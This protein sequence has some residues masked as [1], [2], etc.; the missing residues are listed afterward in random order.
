MSTLHL[1]QLAPRDD[2]RATV[3][4]DWC[5]DDGRTRS[6]EAVCVTGLDETTRKE[7]RWYFEDYLDQL[8]DPPVRLRAARIEERMAV[9][10]EALFRDLFEASPEA[11]EIWRSISE[12]IA[13][14][15]MEITSSV[16]SATAIPWELVQD[17]RAGKPLALIARSFVRIPSQPT[18]TPRRIDLREGETLRILLVICRPDALSDVPFRSVASRLVKELTGE[19]SKRV[20]LTALR[21]PTYEQF[22]TVL[23]TA[24]RLGRPFHL[25]H[26][27]GH[28]FFGD[29]GEGA[30]T[31]GGYL[32]FEDTTRVGRR[33]YVDGQELGAL[34]RE[35][36][37]AGLVLNA[38]QSADDADSPADADQVRAQGSVA[39]E[40]VDA[41][42]GAVLAMRY[43]VYVETATHYVERFY[44][45]L[46]AG[47][48]FGVAATAARAAL[49]A[50]PERQIGGDSAPFRD[51]LVPVV[52]EASPLSVLSTRDAA[53]IF[54]PAGS[55]ARTDDGLPHPPEI[56][57]I[58]GDATLLELDRA[59]DVHKTILLHAYAGSGKSTTAVEFARWY[60]DTRGL[61]GP[62]WLESFETYRPLAR[63]LDRIEETFGDELETKNVNWSARTVGAP[64][65]IALEILA[66]TPVFWIWDNVEE[67]AGFPAGAP[68]LWSV[69]EQTALR[70]FLVRLESTQARVLL[71]SRRDER[72]WLG[73][74]PMR[75]MPGPMPMR[76]RL[77]MAGALA[78]RHGRDPDAIKA[79]RP[80]L[81]WTQGNPM[82]LT[83]VVGQALRDSIETAPL[84]GAFVERL[85][86]GEQAFDDDA[87]QG[88]SRSLG[89][90]L[91][92]GFGA[93]FTANEQD[94]LS[95]LHLFPGPVY[96]DILVSM[97]A[98]RNPWRTPLY[99]GLDRAIW[100]TL[101]DRAAEVGLLTADGGPRYG[102]HPALAWFA[103]QPYRRASDLGLLHAYGA[104]QY[105]NH[106]ALA[107]FFRSR[108]ECLFAGNILPTRAWV[109][110]IGELAD[111]L[112]ER[113]DRGDNAALGR[114]QR[115]EANLLQAY[116]LSLRHGWWDPALSAMQ[117]LRLTHLSV[118]RWGSWAA[119]VIAIVPLVEDPSSGEPRP[120]REDC[121]SLVTEYRVDLATHRRDPATAINLLQRLVAVAR[122]RVAP[123]LEA[124]PARLDDS[125]RHLIRTLTVAL[126]ELGRHQTD[127]GDP[128][129]LA[130]FGEV[131]TMCGRAGLRREA[132]VAAFNLGETYITVPAIRDLAAAEAAF[133]ES[134]DLHL[135]DE[136]IDRARCYGQLGNLA[137][138]RYQDADH[139]G[140][141]Q[142]ILES[143]FQAAIDGH[144]T[145]LLLLPDNADDDRAVAHNQLGVIFNISEQFDTA[146][147]HYREAVRHFEA[148]GNSY[149]AAIARLNLAMIL[150]VTQRFDD[151]LDYACAALASFERFEGQAT[152]M[153][154]LARHLI[155]A[156]EARDANS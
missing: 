70:D 61:Q 69:E 154:E 138:E 93:A 88:R 121:W 37:V 99:A 19:G 86:A 30:A 24:D 48:S 1:H 100:T 66:R 102:N 90:S 119:L 89:A 132:A 85:T 32:I 80:L 5:A 105:G 142:A 128:A 150:R 103:Q 126:H 133:R 97:G 146:I 144:Q 3:S 46:I 51:W 96:T 54:A 14:T 13:E 65:E 34:L 43:K 94:L 145:A 123:A 57:V 98:D 124:D 27:D 149:R 114:L 127:A 72:A 29:L 109:E 35:H 31:R 83:V 104:P 131:K 68:S 111:F 81:A 91:D 12:N 152:D 45:L 23:E 63:V 75:V 153:V 92:Y 136:R 155:A 137:F 21:P 73:D 9:L 22:R 50:Q 125:G 55:A 7:M 112:A 140:A 28:G 139:A 148:S 122:R 52:F 41:G 117:G 147:G 39:Q 141:D 25:V 38:C 16:A 71:T 26:F 106:P 101:L 56:G 44:E 20:E 40:A 134:L 53:A 82:T 156:I 58:G 49:A 8:Y 6:V 74:L 84:V 42:L 87:R 79:L 33:R 60:R 76:E 129:S 59:F 64:T 77:Q 151:A 10:G 62:T 108:F 116:T 113:F 18:V 130:T 120:G 4:V 15:R 67:V 2:G 78:S 143:H 17:P 47:H 36:G 110:A 135:E 11:A 118:G 95:L 107:W 115:Q